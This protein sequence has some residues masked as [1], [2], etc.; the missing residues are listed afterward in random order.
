M[1]S[2]RSIFVGIIVLVVILIGTASAFLLFPGHFTIHL[3]S[4]S[5]NSNGSNL[6]S[7][8]S[9]SSSSSLQSTSSSKSSTS[10]TTSLTSSTTSSISSTGYS[11][12]VLQSGSGPILF[13]ALTTPLAKT[14][15]RGDGACCGGTGAND[16]NYSDDGA[17]SWITYGDFEPGRAWAV[18]N[19][20]GLTIADQTCSSTGNPLR[21]CGPYWEWYGDGNE[22][23]VSSM[24][25]Q[26]N[27]NIPSNA[28]VYSI[29]ATIPYWSYYKGCQFNVSS[30]GCSYV[31]AYGTNEFGTSSP[32]PYDSAF[33]SLSNASGYSVDVGFAE[34]CNGPA[35]PCTSNALELVAFTSGGG[36]YYT[37]LL[38]N[39]S[40]SSYTPTHKLTI[41]T[42]RKSFIDLFV[43][44]NLVYSSSTIPVNFAS[45]CSL[46]FFQF[47]NV[48]NET[49]Y[50]TWSNFTIYSSSTVTVQGLSSGMF[51]IASGANGFS[52]N[53]SASAGVAVVDV[54]P[55]P[56][57][58]SIS[59]ELN[60]QIIA[61]ASKIDA[62]A[63]LE[64]TS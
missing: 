15:Y 55:D 21:V 17:S 32:T 46:S 12:R 48:D 39:E 47:T 36:T 19:S 23:T 45:C 60:G 3:P 61:T 7:A 8:A 5:T 42:D 57:N 54:A 35:P 53:V 37:Q 59:I 56:V 10:T 24:Y 40:V 64:L 6:T 38:K 63:V 20:S 31:Y 2:I 11:L 29:T 22:E 43:D 26:S 33:W 58:L 52:A 34:I 27:M 49:D 9:S 41:A 50:T 1:A 14:Y 13:S 25:A 44:N 28:I 16:I 4:S 51:V 62:G 18:A 30:T